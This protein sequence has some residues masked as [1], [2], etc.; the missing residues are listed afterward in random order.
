MCPHDNGGVVVGWSAA[1]LEDKE[2]NPTHVYYRCTR[3][4]KRV[5]WFAGDWVAH[6][7]GERMTEENW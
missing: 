2:G 7:D 3:C 6:N 5:E 4:Q 1:L